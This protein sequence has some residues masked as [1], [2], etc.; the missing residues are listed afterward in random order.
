MTIS[1]IDKVFKG[2]GEEFFGVK[3]MEQITDEQ[4]EE[5]RVWTCNEIH[6]LTALYGLQEQGTIKELFCNYVFGQFM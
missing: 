2:Y 4:I 1:A 3:A 5:A 6:R